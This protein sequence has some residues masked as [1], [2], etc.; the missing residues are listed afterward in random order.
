MDNTTENS[1]SHLKWYVIAVCI[2]VAGVLIFFNLK[3]PKYQSNEFIGN[4][5]R[6]DNNTLVVSGN[7]RLVNGM[8]LEESRPV[9]VKVIVNNKT[10]IYKTSL[11]IPPKEELDKTGGSFLVKDLPRETTEVSFEE[12][13]E[14]GSGQFASVLVKSSEG[15]I[16]GKSS[17][18]AS[19]LSYSIPISPP[20]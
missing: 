2:I 12:F 15:N 16:Y 4:I 11:F 19:D 7:Y 13:V 20:K 5:D 17:F 18:E 3:T 10:K 6:I 9:T 14:Y 8:D 1:S